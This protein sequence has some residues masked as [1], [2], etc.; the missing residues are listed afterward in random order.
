MKKSFLLALCYFGVIYFSDAQSVTI[1]PGDTNEG[2]IL[3]NS[4]TKPVV[5]IFKTGISN[6]PKMVLQ[7]SPFNTDWGL[8]YADVGDKFNF[9]GDSVNVATFDL[10]NKSV[11][12]GTF[13]PVAK[14]HINH[15]GSDVNPHIRINSTGGSFSRI[16]WTTDENSNRW[17][18]QS[19]LNSA[20]E[21][22]NYWRIEY[23]NLPY[24]I[25]AV[26]N[27]NVGL[28]ASTPSEKLN[29]RDGNLLLETSSTDKVLVKALGTG[30]AGEMIMY[31]NTGVKSVEIRASDAAAS[32][33][34]MN[35]YVPSTGARTLE[36]DGD[37]SGSG[38]S[39]IVVDE[40]QIKGGADLA[41]YFNIKAEEK[42]EAG[43]VVSVLSDNSGNLGISGK[44]YDKN[45]VGIVSGAN[46]VSAG[47]M[48][49]QKDNQAVSGDYP[50]AINGRVYVKADAS[51]AAIK[52]GDLLT[53]SDKAGY[54]MKVSNYKK[55]QGAII[56]KALTGLDNNTGLVLVLL[57]VK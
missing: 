10:V 25:N 21:A 49:H 48:L 7:H 14:L 45:V 57:G 22:S 47:L 38:K 41:E 40:L 20:S 12:I 24:V 3:S 26:G 13:S 23:N 31:T 32:A 28:G 11:G 27:G 2:N 35:F 17:V 43:T 15:A 34:E 5:N 9:I 50:I 51:K 44:A 39:R 6:P 29:I 37:W 8:Q 16:N 19:Y 42:V 55:A 56:G 4:G 36:I 18:A 54:A 1:L 30:S 53:T 46:G 33:G 52:P